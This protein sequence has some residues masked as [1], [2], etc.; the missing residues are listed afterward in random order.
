L[1]L[2]ILVEFKTGTILERY[3]A[4]GP[5]CADVKPIIARGSVV[6]DNKIAVMIV[7]SHPIVREGLRQFLEE[8]GFCIVTAEAGDG[9]SALEV[10]E[11]TE[12]DVLLI[13]STLPGSDIFDILA[14]YK[15]LNPS[16]KIVACYIN[17]DTNLLHE[18]RK[19]GVD[20][21][22][23]KQAESTEY[24]SAVKTVADGGNYFSRNLAD[25]IFKL[26][27]AG[28]DPGHAY[29]LTGREVEILALLANGLCNK[30]IANEFD[31]SV[32]TVETHRLNIRRKTSSNTLSDLVKIARSIGITHLG[33]AN[34]N[35]ANNIRQVGA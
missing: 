34:A 7:D 18:F 13:N 11:Q 8:D 35:S 15:K 27:R 31:L 16:C 2:D 19:F 28:S 24:A 33:D 23:G 5:I 29:G 17:D 26:P 14:Q 21:F 6:S 4:Y 22:I 30:E 10:S 3:T 9:K 12:H 25:A 20:G 32:R 1:K